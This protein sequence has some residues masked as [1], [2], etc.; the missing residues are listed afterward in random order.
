MYVLTYSIDWA[1]G[2]DSYGIVDYECESIRYPFE[3]MTGEITKLI[4]GEPEK[5]TVEMM[6]EITIH[7]REKRQKKT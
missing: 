2:R 4:Q 6:K 3:T 7:I 1:D 5:R